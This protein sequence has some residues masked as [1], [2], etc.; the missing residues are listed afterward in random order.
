MFRNGVKLDVD[1]LPHIDGKVAVYG[2]S[3]LGIAHPEGKELKID[4]LLV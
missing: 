1:Q 2:D 4:K 3:F